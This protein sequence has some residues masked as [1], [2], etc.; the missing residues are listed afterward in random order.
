M[1][2]PEIF[3]TVDGMLSGSELCSVLSAISLQFTEWIKLADRFLWWWGSFEDTIWLIHLHFQLNVG[4]L[5][6]EVKVVLQDWC[7][8]LAWRVFF[9]KLGDKNMSNLSAVWNGIKLSIAV[10]LDEEWI[11]NTFFQSYSCWRINPK[12]KGVDNKRSVF[13]VENKY[14]CWHC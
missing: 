5:V 8:K 12:M 1:I 13:M 14:I 2:V 9:F 10:D 11:I 4:D 6:V 3:R 7:W